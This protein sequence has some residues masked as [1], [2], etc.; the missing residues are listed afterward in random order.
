ML[1]IKLVKSPIGNVPRNRATVAALGL[2]K[3]NQVVEHSDSPMIRGMVHK[4]K[5][6]LEVE[7]VEGTPKSNLA[8]LRK[9]AKP[10]AS[11]APAKASKPKAEKAAKTEKAPAEEAKPKRTSTK[12]AKTEEEK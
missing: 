10:A 4:V 1:R 3:I 12:K 11:A 2:R 8:N 6:M 5:H 7:E 9:G